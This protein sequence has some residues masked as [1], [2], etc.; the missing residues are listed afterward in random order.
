VLLTTEQEFKTHD[1]QESHRGFR[2]IMPK[3]LPRGKVKDEIMTPYK[4]TLYRKRGIHLILQLTR[5]GGRRERAIDVVLSWV[6][7]YEFC[8]D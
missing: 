2:E 6:W 4:Y 8:R 5:S 1:W 7:S 3:V